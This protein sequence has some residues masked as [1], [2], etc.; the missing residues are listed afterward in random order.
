MSNIQKGLEW[1]NQTLIKL[2]NRL[3]DTK[4][5]IPIIEDKITEQ[6]QRLVDAM[7]GEGVK[8]RMNGRKVKIN[9]GRISERVY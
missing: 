8:V 7:A 3:R 1:H 6:K 2:Q 9:D 5:Q 4:A